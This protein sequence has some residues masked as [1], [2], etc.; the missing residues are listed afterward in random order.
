MRFIAFRHIALVPALAMV[1]AGLPLGA[2]AIAA[3]SDSGVIADPDADAL[4]AQMRL[5]GANPT[6]EGALITAGELTLKLGDLDAAAAFFGRA[7]RVN[8]R[9][10]RLKV[11]TARTVL[12]L[13]RP[14]EALRLFDQAVALG[15]DPAN[16]AAE[17]GL[18]YDLIGEQERAQRDYRA[19][20]KRGD[21]D[22]TRR[23]YALSLGISGKRDQ[24]FEQIDTLLRRGDRGAWRVRAFI[25]AMTGDV[26]GA[27]Q[28]ATSMLPQAMASGLLPFFRILPTLGPADRAFAVHFGEVRPTPERIADARLIPPLPVLAPEPVPVQVAVA[29]PPTPRGAPP[30]R[31]KRRGGRQGPVEVAA[32]TLPPVVVPALPPPPS[33]RT[34]APA[35]S[36]AAVT[37]AP[38][39]AAP[40]PVVA[41]TAASH[42][43]AAAAAKTVAPPPIAASA[44]TPPKPAPKPVPDPVKPSVVPPVAPP[45]VPP[46][47]VAGPAPTQTERPAVLVAEPVAALSPAAPP[48]NLEGAAPTTPVATEDSIVARIVATIGVPASELDVGPAP[49]PPAPPV[50]AATPI[51]IEPAPSAPSAAEIAEQERLARKAAAKAAADKAA[52]DKAL[53]DKKAA[54]KQAAEEKAAKAK[55]LK[56]DP[57]RIWVQVAGGANVDALPRAWATLRAK[58]PAAFKNRAGYTT[59]LRFTNRLLTGP[60][61]TADEAQDFVNLIAKSGLTGFVFTSEAGQKIDKLPAR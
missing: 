10:S 23:R 1:L 13:E 45:A 55:A 41:A 6:D 24:A 25:L 4:A 52:A 16:F 19:A 27:E 56:A 31:G 39:P 44:I 49:A 11:G 7:E 5:L 32:V 59:P 29:T 43:V 26:A 3:Q 36:I 18:A 60:F 58:A 22:E 57:S 38:N 51:A 42:N 2:A 17:R 54:D 20:L 46:A 40:A 47:V 33:L 28:I 35:G 34:A 30:P 15:Y 61:K 37:P 9:N 14:G 48:A 53:A 8:P 21:D 50:A 12:H